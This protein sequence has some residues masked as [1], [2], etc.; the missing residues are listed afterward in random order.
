MVVLK[1]ERAFV[2]KNELSYKNPQNRGMENGQHEWEPTYYLAA[3][4]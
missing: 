3:P 2:P 4:S 1:T